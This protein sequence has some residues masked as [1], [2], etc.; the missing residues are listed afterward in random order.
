ML[1]GPGV[2]L[3]V[4]IE[5]IDKFSFDPRKKSLSLY[6]LEITLVLNLTFFRWIVGDFGIPRCNLL[7]LQGG[8]PI[9]NAEVLR[10]TLSGAK[11]AIADA[12]V[13]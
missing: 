2:V 10:R 11:G 9:Y 12:F 8:D 3:D 7:D 4:T 6:L 13:S 5:N 1:S